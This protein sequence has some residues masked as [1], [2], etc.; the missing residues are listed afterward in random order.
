MRFL[1]GL[2]TVLVVL[3]VAYAALALIASPRPPHA[4]ERYLQTGVSVLAHAGGNLLWPDN[5]MAAFTGAAAMGADVLELDVH[6]V[7]D[8]EFV[9]IHD[10]TVDRTT[11][12][13]GQVAQMDMLELRRLDAGYRWTPL[14]PSAGEEGPFP[15]RGAGVTLP[16]LTEV[17]GAFPDK[18]VNVEIKQ[19]DPDVAEALC[20]LLREQ[21]AA[22]RVMV[23]SFHG[24]A[25]SQ[26]RRACPEVATSASQNEVIVFLALEKLRLSAIFTPQYEA[27]QV[28]ISQYNVPI[29]TQHFVNAAAARGV[30][31]H[32]WTVNDVATMRDLVSLGVNGLITDR[33][34]RALE[35]LGRPGTGIPEFVEP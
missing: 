28:P 3:G 29:V 11:D 33:P 25:L 22:D 13:A 21:D 8:G 2:I 10:A 35:V 9:V 20:V 4:Y 12:G 30:D 1:R 24:G 31:V 14:G 7:A 16:T 18:A 26:F 5:T 19:N 6:R 27:L 15:Y 17:L 34:D 23:G 32:V